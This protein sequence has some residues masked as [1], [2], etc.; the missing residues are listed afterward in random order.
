MRRAP[1][2]GLRRQGPPKLL[3]GPRKASPSRAGRT[4]RDR[5]GTTGKATMPGSVRQ[6]TDLA[7]TNRIARAW[8]GDEGEASDA[9]L[10]QTVDGPCKAQTGPLGL[11]RGTAEESGGKAFFELKKGGR[12][13]TFGHERSAPGQPGAWKNYWT[14][15][16]LQARGASLEPWRL[17]SR[18]QPTQLFSVSLVVWKV[19]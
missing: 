1:R 3:R 11:E 8:A 2:S 5:R 7:A 16:L 10:S 15:Q 6:S 19:R 9:W 12:D 14:W 4:I 13:G 17:S 18:W